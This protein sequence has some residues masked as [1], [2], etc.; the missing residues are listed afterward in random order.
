MP[1][2]CIFHRDPEEE[3]FVP[4]L[5]SYNPSTNSWE[6]EKRVKDQGSMV[7][8]DGSYITLYGCGTGKPVYCIYAYIPSDEYVCAPVPGL[9]GLCALDH[10]ESI[11][12]QEGGERPAGTRRFR[13]TSDWQAVRQMLQSGG[14][15][16]SKLPVLQLNTSSVSHLS[17]NS[18][19][20]FSGGGM[21]LSSVMSELSHEDDSALRCNKAKVVEVAELTAVHEKQIQ[22]YELRIKELERSVVDLAK[23]KDIADKKAKILG[24]ERS[25][26]YKSAATAE[27]SKAFG[28]SL[29]ELSDAQGKADDASVA[30]QLSVNQVREAS[31]AIHNARFV[32]ASVAAGMFELLLLKP[33][34]IS[35][36]AF[37]HFASIQISILIRVL[38]RQNF[39][40]PITSNA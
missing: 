29:D 14:R 38:V 13:L 19:T 30:Y 2:P 8:S 31:L 21:S 39:R 34:G 6:P 24:A 37:P 28:V 5:T 4:S 18:M 9:D 15:V 7:L 40:S 17:Q 16:P 26:D 25:E 1:V 36:I 27:A 11:V 20:Q 12:N 33:L 23:A 10:T 32:V 35:L 22:E 3:D